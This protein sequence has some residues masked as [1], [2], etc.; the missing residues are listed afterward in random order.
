MHVNELSR[1]P[2]TMLPSEENLILRLQSVGKRF[3]GVV[4][5]RDVSFDIAR[6]SSHVLLGENGGR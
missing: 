2:G 3:P 4:A 1:S 6:G 5:L